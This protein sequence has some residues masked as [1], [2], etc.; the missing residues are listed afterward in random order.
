MSGVTGPMTV[1]VYHEQAQPKHE[2]KCEF[3]KCQYI[4]LPKALYS[5][6]IFLLEFLKYNPLGLD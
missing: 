2:N 3:S 1:R 4:C 5:E 6:K